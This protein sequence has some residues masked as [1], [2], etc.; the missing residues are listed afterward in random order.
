MRT[1]TRAR[2]QPLLSEQDGVLTSAQLA[3]LGIDPELPRRAGW[4]ALAPRVWCTT[5]DPPSDEQLL[6]GLRLH[7]GPDTVPSGALACR[8][9]GLRDVPD[10]AVA[11]VLVTHGRRL[12]SGGLTVVHQSERMPDAIRRGGWQLAPASRAVADAVRWSGGL[13]PARAL[14]LAAL[15]DQF[16]VTG[17]LERE[18]AAGQRRGS[19][20]LAHAL[21]DWRQ[22]ARSA[23]EAE[24]ADALRALPRSTRLP[25]FLLNPILSLHGRLIGTPDGYLPELA[26]GWEVDSLRHH[27][28]SDD[29]AATLARHQAFADAGVELVH[30][31]PTAFRRDRR[32]WARTFTARAARHAAQGRRA[33]AGL[34]VL[35]ADARLAPPASLVA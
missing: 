24:V 30:V 13:R 10:R 32:G 21:D 12:T 15:A 1:A 34:V 35:P 26:L 27:G 5:G 19:A 9:L 16:V 28:S 25:P 6:E 22:G 23:P 29:L 33:P 4:T 8:R 17:D 31:V 20:A 18:L 14:V 2:L 11:D 7:T 3:D